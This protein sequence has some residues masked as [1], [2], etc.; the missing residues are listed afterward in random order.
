[1][2]PQLLVSCAN[3]WY[4]GLQYGSV[5]LSMG[6]CAI[7]R[8][9]LRL[10]DETTCAN[11]LRK[12]MLFHRAIEI[13]HHH[14]RYFTRLDCV[15][16]LSDCKPVTNKEYLLND[17]RFLRCDDVGEAVA[18]YG[19]YESKIESLAQLRTIGTFRAEFAMLSLA[20][21]YT[22]RCVTRGGAWT[23]GIHIYWW[24]R[25]KLLENKFPVILPSDLRYSTSSSL[26]Q[27]VELANW[28]LLMFRLVFISDMGVHASGSNIPLDGFE[29]LPELAAVETEIPSTKRLQSWIK[30]KGISIL[31]SALPERKYREICESFR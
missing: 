16:R 31:E 28:S 8:V 27:Q 6:Y 26:D 4:N 25:R 12:D 9:V 14:Q 3:C 10:P 11:H 15:Q 24:T 7:H 13:Q 1:M 5:G 18:D 30:N 2:Q 20:R 29:T 17:T 19:E 23:S 22:L 21:A